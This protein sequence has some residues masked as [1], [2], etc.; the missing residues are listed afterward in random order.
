MGATTDESLQTRE[1]LAIPE[2]AQW[3]T[4]EFGEPFGSADVLRA[5]L[6]GHLKLSVDFVNGTRALKGKVIGGGARSGSRRPPEPELVDGRGVPLTAALLWPS[7]GTR[8]VLS[9]GEL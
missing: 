9:E 3:L 8:P 4:L 5:S 1:W 7:G 2:A 6:D